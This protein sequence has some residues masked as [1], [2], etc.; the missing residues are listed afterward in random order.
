MPLPTPRTTCR[1]SHDDGEESGW[2][3]LSIAPAQRPHHGDTAEMSVLGVRAMSASEV[4]V[5]VSGRC[6]RDR[7]GRFTDESAASKCFRRERIVA[8]RVDSH[9]VETLELGLSLRCRRPLLSANTPSHM[10]GSF[11]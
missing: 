11:L 1:H 8:I 9:P 7:G 2:S 3:G 10:P 6:L 5:V 4:L